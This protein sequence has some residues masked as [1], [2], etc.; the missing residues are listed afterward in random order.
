MRLASYHTPVLREEVLAW[1]ITSTGGVYVDATLG[2]GGHAESILQRLEPTGMLVGL[3]A[4]PDAIQFAT[5]QLSSF[6]G[7]AVLVH[8]QF[9]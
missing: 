9:S 4:D 3:D 7:R 8:E 6:Q 1:L 5:T 2:G